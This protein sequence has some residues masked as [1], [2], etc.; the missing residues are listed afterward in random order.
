MEESLIL[1]VNN[2]VKYFPV[3]SGFIHQKKV[4]VKAADG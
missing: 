3:T 1:K 2:L 4:D